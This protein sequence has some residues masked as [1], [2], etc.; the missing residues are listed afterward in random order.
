[1]AAHKLTD[2]VIR[3]QGRLGCASQLLQIFEGLPFDVDPYWARP[4]S[5]PH[6]GP[7]QGPWIAQ[8]GR[9]PIGKS[10]LG[11]LQRS[12]HSKFR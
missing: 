11:R 9:A 5:M 3:P 6:W 12:S 2:L 10:V 8:P 1:M 7:F 4:G